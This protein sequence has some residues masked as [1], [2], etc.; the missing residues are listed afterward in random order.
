MKRQNE[1]LGF[2]EN[3]KQN[4]K[5]YIHQYI[6]LRLE[7]LGLIDDNSQES[8]ADGFLHLAKSLIINYRERERQFKNYLCP[9]DQRIQ[10]FIKN[11]F[12]GVDAPEINIPSFTFTLD[13]YGIA[14]EL[15]IPEKRE[16]YISDYLSSYRIKQGILHNPR[17]DRRTTK[18]VFHIAEGGLP[19]PDDKKAVPLLTAAYLLKRSTEIEGDLFNLPFTEEYTK[20]SK[21]FASLLLRPLVSP[22]VEGISPKKSMEVRFF[23]PGSLVS[24]LDFVESIFGNAGSPYH[25]SNDAG[26]DFETWSGHTGCIILAPQLC[27][28][29]KKEAGLPHISKATEREKRD[30]MC[31]DKESELYNEGVPFK[32]TMRSDEGVIVTVIADNYFGYSKKEIKTFISYA[33]NL[34]GNAEEEHAGGALIFPSYN[35]GEGQITK[36]ESFNTTLDQLSQLFPDIIEMKP[37]GYGIDKSYPDIFYIPEL[38]RFDIN[39]Q[40]VSWTKKKQ[41]YSVKLLPNHTYILPNGHKYTME[42]ASGTLNYRLVETNAEGVFIHKPCTVSGGGKSEISKSISD[43]IISGS[44]FIKDFDSDF[45]RVEE[46]IN[47]NYSNRFKESSPL[48]P[49][50]NTSRTF[51]S[52]KRSM[53]SSIKMLT[54][55]HEFTDEYNA[56]LDSIPQYIKGIAFIVKRFYREEWGSDWK[57]YFSVDILNG[58]PGNELKYKNRKLAARYLRLGYDDKGAW[59]TFKMRQDYVHSV[60]IQ[61]E[62][63]ITVSTVIPTSMLS[64]LNP[65][66]DNKSVKIL[67]NCEYRFFQR[68]DEAIHRGLDKKAESDLSTPNTF[69][70]NFEPLTTEDAIQMVEDVIN[71]DLFTPPMRE[72]VEGVAGSD[73]KEYFVSSSNPRV[74]DGALTK[75]V[76]YLQTRDDIIDP[77]SKY[78][79]EIGMRISRM[80][81]TSRPLYVPVNAVLPGRRNNPAEKGIRPLAVYSPVHYQELPELFM[82][83]ICS[84]TGKSP[85]TTGAGS[86]GALTKSPFNALWPVIDLNN[87]LLSFILTGY[88]GF[89][90]PAGYIGQKYRIDHDLSLLI[91]ELWARLHPFERDPKLMISNGDLEK[92]DDFEFKGKTIPASILGYRITEKFVNGFFGRVFENPDVIFPEDM[93]KPEL[94]SLDQFA[95]GVL[96]IVESQ[97]K[98]AGSYFRDGSVNSAIPPLKALLHIMANGNFEGKD[99]NSPEVRDLFKYENVI[100]SDWYKARILTK[101]QSDIS[102]FASHIRYIE[103]IIRDDQNLSPEMYQDLIDRLNRLKGHYDHV[104]SYDYAKGLTGTIGKSKI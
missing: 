41:E 74:V 73:K 60:K 66:V 17:N 65:I 103:K 49:A 38:S 71:F 80:L 24:N 78:I 4:S 72:L 37:G 102:L 33:A 99:L 63:D 76:R 10:N 92:I 35:Q 79:A 55:S 67:Q 18:G 30:G 77:K 27:K 12:K 93:L 40:S 44:F 96:N 89:T 45:K 2:F 91:P 81:P 87:A 95:D 62:D 58:Q 23:A 36:P 43:S 42:R 6:K 59:R 7:A 57:K 101:Q 28:V 85:S 90:T 15:S 98:V 97:Q 70:S 29:T 39:K 53:G 1:S 32:L 14:R 75:N 94:Q 9:A 64:G 100:E 84:L 69:I 51:L 16:E 8:D 82:D 83:F 50:K 88:H 48:K 47:Y 56:W 5:E 19:I 3:S 31:W 11:Y 52:S 68:P 86:E 21:I 20:K 34:M 22:E 25:I 46:I 104:C 54:P 26:L 13:F 61:M